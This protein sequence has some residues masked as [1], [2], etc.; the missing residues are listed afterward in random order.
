[1]PLL[2][3]AIAFITDTIFSI[4]FHWWHIASF[5]RCHSC[6]AF[7]LHFLERRRISPDIAAFAIIDFAFTPYWYFSFIISHDISPR[8]AAFLRLRF[9]YFHYFIDFFSIFL[10]YIAIFFLPAF[11]AIITPLLIFAIDYHAIAADITPILF[12]SF[13]LSLLAAIAFIFLIFR[14]LITLSSQPHF[15]ILAARGRYF[16]V[17]AE[18]PLAAIF[19]RHAASPIRCFAAAGH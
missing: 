9:H 2:I 5:F 3:F 4:D 12:L 11:A 8:L 19:S 15:A 1:M 17:R 18:L 16:I 14:R 7:F 13:S 10:S 6:I